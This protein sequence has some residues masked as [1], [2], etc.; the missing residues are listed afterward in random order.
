MANPTKFDPNRK[1]DPE[2]LTSFSYGKHACFGREKGKAFLNGMVKLAAE[3]RNLR[4]AA[5]EMGTVKTIQ[6]GGVKLFLNDSWSSLGYD[7]SSEFQAL[8]FE[9]WKLLADLARQLGSCTSMAMVRAATL[10]A[11]SRRIRWI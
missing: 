9:I 10:V 4:P 7:A 2:T 5:G 1:S 11:V 3:L 8:L 6:M